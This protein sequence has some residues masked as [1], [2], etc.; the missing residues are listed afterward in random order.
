MDSIDKLE[1]SGAPLLN[2][3][4]VGAGTD[5]GAGHPR[6]PGLL[7]FCPHRLVDSVTDIVPEELYARGIRGVIL[8][9]DNTLVLWQKEQI[10]DEILAWL[11]AL[12]AA[13]MKL[14][15]LSNSI[16]SK[17]SARLAVKLECFN[18]RKARK[19]TLGGFRRAMAMMETIPATTAM[20][21]DQM[22]TDVWGGTLIQCSW[23]E[24]AFLPCAI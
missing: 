18:V 2:E 8:D 14:A 10:S 23:R 15:L 22:F 1:T 12:Q 5:G 16:L 4:S 11:K 24:I 9:L 7:V 21:G 17:R 19:P 13:G 3:E 20:V 6:R